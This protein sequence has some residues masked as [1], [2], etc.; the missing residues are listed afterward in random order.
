M[1]DGRPRELRP[2]CCDVWFIQTDSCYE[3]L[4]DHAFS[5]IGAVLFNPAGKP[6]RFFSERLT[7]QIL[8]DV[9]PSNKKTIIFECELFAL[10]CSIM[11][12]SNL[13][14]GSTVF[15]TDNNAVRDCLISCSAGNVI[16]R[17]M[18]VAVLA[19]ESTEQF[20]AWY[21]RVPTDSNMA[22]DPSRLKTDRMLQLGVLQDKLDVAELWERHLALATAWGEEQ[23]R[24]RPTGKTSD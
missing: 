10:L 19:L 21:A 22:D 20:T 8:L 1:I 17:R 2:A 14:G 7:P 11:V 3:Q 16:A 6:V 12:G 15:Y 24:A 13:M 23:A 9:N 5:G 4:G 18:L